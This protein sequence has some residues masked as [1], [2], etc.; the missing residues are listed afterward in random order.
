VTITP[1]RLHGIALLLLVSLALATAAGQAQQRPAPAAPPA[2]MPAVDPD[3]IAAM[4]RMGAYLRTLKTFQVEAVTTREDVLD[5]GQKVLWSGVVNLL[6]QMPDRLRAEVTSD[7]QDRMYFYDGKNFTLWARRPN[8]YATVAAPPTLGQLADTLEDKYGLEVPLVDLF[9]WGA[10]GRTRARIT[11]ASEIGPSSV[12]GTTCQHYAYRQ[13]GLDWQLWIQLGAYPLPRKLV[14]TTTTDAARPQ[15]SAIYTWNLAPSADDSV[16]TFAPP[17]G[18]KKII[19][20]VVPPAGTTPAA[21][22]PGTK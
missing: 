13:D 9:R 19:M 12:G 10:P 4:D 18:A 7:K 20:A 6:A 17:T 3:A 21:S 2:S 11:A 22:P 15:S 14:I 5:D 8:Y 16:F 1:A